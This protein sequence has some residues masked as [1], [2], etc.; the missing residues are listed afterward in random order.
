MNTLPHIFTASFYDSEKWFENV[1]ITPERKVSCFEIELFTKDGGCS[2]IN[3]KKHEIKKGNLLITKPNDKRYSILD[4]SCKYLHFEVTDDETHKLLN[5]LPS[6]F[7]SDLT[8][9]LSELFDR[10]HNTMISGMDFYEVFAASLLYRLICKIKSL[11]IKALQSSFYNDNVNPVTLAIDF[12]N[13][14]YS[15]QISN[16]DIAIASSLSIS[17]LH[18]RF[19]EATGVTPNT[20]LNRVRISAAK[21]LLLTSDYSLSLISHRCGFSSDT[22]FNSYFKKAVGISPAKYRKTARYPIE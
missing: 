9:E 3:G 2:V 12:I 11:E 18:K 7:N 20:Y 1:K 22:Y 17:Y 6:F 21:E 15:E 16:E 4:F 14:N 13:K 10:I 5:S 8:N 19:S